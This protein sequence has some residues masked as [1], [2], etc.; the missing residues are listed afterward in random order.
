MRALDIP[1]NTFIYSAIIPNQE[2][3]GR[4]TQVTDWNWYTS[5]TKKTTYLG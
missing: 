3:V 1:T 4:E 5:L 2:T